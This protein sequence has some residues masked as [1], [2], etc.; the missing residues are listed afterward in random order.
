MGWRCAWRRCTWSMGGRRFRWRVEGW[1]VGWGSAGSVLRSQGSSREDRLLRCAQVFFCGLLPMLAPDRSRC[2]L[3]GVLCG[4]WV[5]LSAYG[6]GCVGRFL[7]FSWG[8]ALWFWRW[9]DMPWGALRDRSCARREA[10]GRIGFCAARRVFVDRFQ[11]S[12]RTDPAA[13]WWAGGVGG[14]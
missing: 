9:G 7:G 13:A 6:Y 1:G 4:R 2:R 3:L 12:L 8:S 14:G 5:R 10:R 11:C